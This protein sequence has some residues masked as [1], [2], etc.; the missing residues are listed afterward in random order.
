MKKI[1]FWS[2]W[3]EIQKVRENK[4]KKE[5]IDLANEYIV[6]DP[7]NVQA[8]MQLIDIYYLMW[9]LEMAE[10]PIDFILSK[11]I[12]GIDIS[13]L[14]YVKAVLLSER[15]DWLWAKKH[16]KLALKK[17]AD[18]LEYQRLLSTI[19]YWSWNRTKWYE[20]LKQVLDKNN[21]DPDILLD[22]VNMALPLWYIKEA[23][24]YVNIYFEKRD[25]MR[26]L[27]KPDTY[28][29]KR[30]LNFKDALFHNNENDD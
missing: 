26:F 28:Y 5:A 11:N 25:S 8:Y 2:I 13:L 1:S 24:K 27:S 16:I 9:E 15:T 21:T 19:E 6:K 10:K 20:L 23:K 30:M 17:N 3:D 12:Q 7:F 4:G 22:A 18:N 14:H 29:D